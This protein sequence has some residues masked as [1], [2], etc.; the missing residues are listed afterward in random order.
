MQKRK[1]MREV[2][3]KPIVDK[4]NSIIDRFLFCPK[5]NLKKSKVERYSSSNGPISLNKPIISKQKDLFYPLSV[6]KNLSTLN[7]D[8]FK[9]PSSKIRNSSNIDFI[10][11]QHSITPTFESS[12]KVRIPSKSRAKSVNTR[13]GSKITRILQTDNNII[14]E[15]DS[16]EEDS[17]MKFCPLY[18]KIS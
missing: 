12:S 14:A 4:Y 1:P 6:K 17:P 16:Q 7:I 3:N 11:R 15:N 9:I 13:H 10:I 18:N 5:Q 8:D 2:E